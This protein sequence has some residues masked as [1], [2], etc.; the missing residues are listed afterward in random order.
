MTVIRMANHTGAAFW[1]MTPNENACEIASILGYGT[2]IIDLV[3]HDCAG[4]SARDF[5]LAAFIDRLVPHAPS[6]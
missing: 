4:I 3:T 2:V 5:A 6:T 1:L